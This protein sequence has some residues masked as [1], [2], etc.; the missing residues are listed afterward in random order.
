ME[1]QAYDQWQAQLQTR[2]GELLKEYTRV[3]FQLRHTELEL[4]GEL[5]LVERLMLRNPPRGIRRGVARRNRLSPPKTLTFDD[6]G[7]EPYEL[8]DWSDL[9][10]DQN[11]TPPDWYVKF[12]LNQ[13]SVGSCA[14]EGCWGAGMCRRHQDGQAYVILNPYFPYHTVSGGYDGG[15]SLP[16]NIAF[17]Q[18]YG[19][20]SQEV[21]PRSH[22]WRKKP[23]DEAYQDALQYRLLDDGV[24]Q[25]RSW[26]EFG[27]LV[28]LGIPVY[29]GYS[30]HAIFSSEIISTSRLI[31]VNSWHKSWGD[32]GRGTLSASSIYWNYG[33]YG[34]LSL[35]DKVGA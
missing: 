11:R 31:Y 13:A 18:K 22:G 32:N 30:G 16:D 19:C 12:I 23:S 20:A 2:H 1:V 33:V 28:L 9:I 15:S 4:E 24:V 10:A 3:K 8:R 17:A 7:V 14:C 21:W 26:E 27:T 29:F 25:V 5:D 6:L 34:I 35:F